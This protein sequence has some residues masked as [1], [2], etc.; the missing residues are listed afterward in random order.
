MPRLLPWISLLL[1]LF[2]AGCASARPEPAGDEDR[3]QIGLASYYGAKFHGSRTASGSSYDR[4]ALTA[5]HRTLPFGTRVRVTNLANGREV[6]VTITDRGPFRKD[7]ILDVSSRA[8]R[9]LGFLRDGIA[10]VRVVVLE[11]DRD[12]PRVGLEDAPVE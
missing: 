3:G 1:A 12:E 7:R 10:R 9:I 11:E 6:V 8:A 4:T 2:A 5:A